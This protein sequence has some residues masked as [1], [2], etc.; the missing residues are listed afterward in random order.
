MSGRYCTLNVA[1]EGDPTGIGMDYRGTTSKREHQHTGA[2]PDRHPVEGGRSADRLP[3]M[4]KPPVT[5]RL[6]WVN[7]RKREM[8][9]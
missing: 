7:G 2:W 1:H 8:D 5:R 3:S 4:P 6:T 9:G